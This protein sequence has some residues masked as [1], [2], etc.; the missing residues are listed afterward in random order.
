MSPEQWREVEQLYHAALERKP[1]EREAFLEAAC[2]ANAD[3]RGEVES[4]L[5]QGG[6]LLDHPA[7][8]LCNPVPGSRLGVYE[9]G[10]KI[11]EGGMG[12]VYR[13]RDTK[14]NRTVAI[15]VLPAALAQ[16]PGRLARFEREAQVLAALNH[17]NI[18]QIYSVEDRALVMEL[19]EGETLK[20]PLPLKTALDYAGQIAEALEAAHDKGII[21]R[22][23]KPEN[24]KVTPQGVVKVLDFGLAAIRPESDTTDAA[25]NSPALARATELGMILGTPAYMSPEQARGQPVD[26]RTDIWAFGCVL[27]EMLT[28]QRAFPGQTVSDTLATVIAKEPDIDKVPAKVRRLVQTCL[29]KDPKQRLQAIGDWRLLIEDVSP[30]GKAASNRV[31]WATAASPGF[32]ACSR[33][34]LRTFPSRI[35]S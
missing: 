18:A 20:G 35:N 12:L 22:D 27:Y 15:K 13:A 19:V 14:L 29:E 32:S 34:Q 5:G 6:S 23:L 30:P 17:P 33:R 2:R 25:G 28:G 21:H 24:I 11:G 10:V 8:E 26:R 9:I 4:L 1:E 31:A 3:L 7:W 16:D